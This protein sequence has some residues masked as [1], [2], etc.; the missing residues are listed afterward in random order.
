MTHQRFWM[1]FHDWQSHLQ[2]NEVVPA[3][4][5][6]SRQLRSQGS[7][8]AGGV[9]DKAED[10]LSKK[11]TARV[12]NSH[13][14]ALLFLQS[15]RAFLLHCFHLYFNIYG[16][17]PMCLELC[18][19]QRIKR[20][21]DLMVPRANGWGRSKASSPMREE[22][23]GFL[24]GKVGFRSKRERLNILT[25]SQRAALTGCSLDFSISGEPSSHGLCKRRGTCWLNLWSPIPC[26]WT[27]PRVHF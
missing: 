15:W 17:Y 9:E 27:E 20:R 16:L 23:Y 1:W 22:R 8:S 4:L 11:I 26:T 25:S 24:L 18:K 21:L 2:G 14:Q 19:V 13:S 3:S 6:A 7:W 12:K 5:A 10:V